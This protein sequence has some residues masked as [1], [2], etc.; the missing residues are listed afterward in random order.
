[1]RPNRTKPNKN[2]G[3]STYG[4]EQAPMGLN[5]NQEIIEK[6]FKYEIMRQPLMQYWMLIISSKLGCIFTVDYF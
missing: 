1:M 4:T 5:K 6:Y 3:V 2:S